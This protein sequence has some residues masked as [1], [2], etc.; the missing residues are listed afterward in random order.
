MSLMMT[1]LYS[2]LI[3]FLILS[4]FIFCSER[5]TPTDNNGNYQPPV[6][7][8]W[9]EKTNPDRGPINTIITDF[10]GQIFIGTDTSGVYKSD[11]LGETWQSYNNGLSD[12]QIIC[13]AFDSSGIILAGSS[14]QGIFR[15][16]ILNDQWIHTDTLNTTVWS[17]L[18]L[19]N[20]LVLSGSSAGILKSD[21]QGMSWSL[22]NIPGLQQPFITLAI[23]PIGRI[24]G[25]TFGHGVL[26]SDD[27]G[28]NW[29]NTS[30]TALSVLA[31]AVDSEGTIFIG[32]LSSGTLRS[33]DNGVTWEKMENGILAGYITDIEI[34][35]S[36]DIY[37]A[38]YGYG[39]YRSLNG[40]DSWQTFNEG[41]TD[42]IVTS[43]IFDS[44]DF[45]VAVTESGKVYRTT[46]ST[47]KN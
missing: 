15:S 31:L 24:Y 40:G 44:Q 39:I 9:A 45:L 13:L 16:P 20:G 25:G 37:I 17:I 4:L 33:S 5:D 18:T 34:N 43:I 22:I 38:T 41:L 29:Q 35:S 42:L 32:T 46:L 8:A 30:L 1:R 19:G 28:S 7:Q 21:D 27:Q 47:D 36:Q 2:V 23:N 12:K 26:F 3:S 14:D 6:K 10:Y 11:D